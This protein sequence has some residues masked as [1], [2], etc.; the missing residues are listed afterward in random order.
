[1]HIENFFVR[2]TQRELLQGYII[3]RLGTPLD[4]PGTQPAW[5]LDPS[6]YPGLRAGLVR[7]IAISPVASGWV[8]GVESRGVLDFGLLQAISEGMGTEV[9]ACQVSTSSDYFGLAR[10]V[11]GSLVEARAEY[12]GAEDPV[13]V[14][15]EFLRG[16]SVPFNMIAFSEA[17][18]L[19]N[20]GWEVCAGPANCDGANVHD[21]G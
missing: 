13:S 12:E 11:N 16:R 17:I 4:P 21:N 9:L 10:C 5:G 14:L 8:A 20:G 1:M 18:K 19:R 7:N 2:T 15:R 3:K 6:Y